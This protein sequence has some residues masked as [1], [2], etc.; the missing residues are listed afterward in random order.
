[1][2]ELKDINF[3]A[4]HQVMRGREMQLYSVS[5]RRKGI[6]QYELTDSQFVKMVARKIYYKHPRIATLPK[7]G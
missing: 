7:A 4:M 5:N 2:R 3:D 1:M 6:A